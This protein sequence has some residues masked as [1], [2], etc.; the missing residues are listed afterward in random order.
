MS[1][2]VLV[3]MASIPE[4]VES[5]KRAVGSLVRQ[6]DK[7]AVS[8]NGYQEIPAFLAKWP[9]VEAT[10][11]GSAGGDAEKF[12]AV[13]EWDGYM[14]TCD[15]DLLY[16]NDYIAKLVDGVERYDRA[17][18]VSF[19]G[20]S[21]EGWTHRSCAASVKRIRCLGVLRHDDEDVNVVGTGTMGWHTDRVPVWRAAFRHANMADVQMACLGHLLGL[22]FVCLQHRARWLLDICPPEGPRIY[23]ANRDNL[24]GPQNTRVPRYEELTRVDWTVAPARPKVRVSVATC[25]RPEKLLDL[26][27]DLAREGRWADLEVCVYEDPTPCDY[28]LARE[29]CDQQGWRWH[30]F[31]DRL[32]KRQHWQLVNRELRD[33]SWSQTDWFLFLPDD[34]RLV[35]YAIPKAI[36]TW[37]RLEDPVTL[38]LWRLAAFEGSPS[39]TGRKPVARGDATETFHVDGLYLCRR[40]ALETLRFQVPDV[41]ANRSPE[42]SSG[43]GAWMSKQLHAKRKRMYRVDESLALPNDDGVSVMNPE[44]RVRFPAVAL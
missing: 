40:E 28:T 10:V 17:A 30:R 32:G 19:H 44:D 23:E 9:N 25:S 16:P 7:V 41:G 27:E 29:F 33:A 42:L 35:R 43:V 34:V 12:A 36:Y 4:R 26:L 37:D 3:G 24:D 5:M 6:A 20:G 21:T 38:T 8:L 15:D 1:D 11:R 18:A 39:W 14:A 22:K 13:D 31:P 2:Q